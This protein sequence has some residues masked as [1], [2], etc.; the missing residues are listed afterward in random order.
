MS[1]ILVL[2]CNKGALNGN[3]FPY[4]AWKQ[5]LNALKKN[6]IEK[7]IVEFSAVDSIITKFDP[8][9][10]RDNKGSIVLESEMERVKGYDFK[11]NWRLFKKR[12]Y[13]LL[14]EHTKYCKIA[15]ERLI[16]KYKLILVCISVR[17]YKYAIIRAALTI[18]KDEIPKNM[19]II[20]CGES[21]SFQNNGISLAIRIIKR[22]KEEGKISSGYIIKP[23]KVKLNSKFLMRP[24]NLPKDYVYWDKNYYKFEENLE[25]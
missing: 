20:D 16:M 5:A 25:L 24:E 18:G 10:D 8:V 15:L 12:N 2:P 21:P 4:G 17:G 11:P 1:V 7:K 9:N 3:F 13:E 6:K 19:I 14:K 23:K 22:F